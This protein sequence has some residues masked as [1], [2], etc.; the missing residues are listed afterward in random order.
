MKIIKILFFGVS[1]FSLCSCV[2]LFNST[3]EAYSGPKKTPDQIA[4]IR[5]PETYNSSGY[6]MLSELN[7]KVYGSDLKGFPSIVNVLP[8][9]HKL[10]IK[11]DYYGSYAFPEFEMNFEAGKIYE[12]RCANAGGNRVRGFATEIKK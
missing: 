2:N 9:I 11:C 3:I 5:S 12:L 4:S 10:K 1:I 8:G 6:G 7:G